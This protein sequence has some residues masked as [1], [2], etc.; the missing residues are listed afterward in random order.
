MHHTPTF[1]VISFMS[2]LASLASLS[3]ADEMADKITKLFYD[4]KIEQ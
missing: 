1:G 2:L 4:Y 3:R